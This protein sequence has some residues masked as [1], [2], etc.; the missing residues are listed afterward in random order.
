M[1]A[2]AESHYNFVDIENQMKN[3]ENLSGTT[4]QTE[5]FVFGYISTITFEG[6][7]IVSTVAP[8]PTNITD[9]SRHR[10]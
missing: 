10:F 5:I 6:E 4:P 8:T 2:Q 1:A 7:T 3:L 9:P